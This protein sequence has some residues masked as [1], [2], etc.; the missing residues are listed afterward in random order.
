MKTFWAWLNGNKT[1]I[2]TV[3]FG[4]IA[5]FGVQIGIS[6]EIVDMILWIAGTLGLGSFTHHIKKGYVTI[7]KG[8]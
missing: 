5:K 4:F 8:D 1:I 2:C 3:I 6:G 7:K